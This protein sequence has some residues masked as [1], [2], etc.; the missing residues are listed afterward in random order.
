MPA[1][2]K[3]DAMLNTNQT[4]HTA[5]VGEMLRTWRQRRRLSQLALACDAD[6]SARHLSFLETGRSRPSRQMLTHLAELLDIP[7][8]DRNSLLLAAGFAP[9]HTETPLDNPK[10]AD[11]RRAVEFLLAG[12][13][14]S[15]ALAVD[16]HWTLVAANRAIGLFLEGIAPELLE[17]P[18]NVLRLSLHPQ[19]LAP[20]IVDLR[21]WRGHALERLQKQIDASGDAELMALH[22]ELEAYPC[23]PAS[24]GRK[25]DDHGYGA[26]IVPL[27][28]RSDEG[29]LSFLTTT[30]VFGTAVD[31]TFSELAIESFFPADDFTAEA[32]RKRMPVEG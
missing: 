31:L 23:G 8:R 28:V 29:V 25:P 27:R 26:I 17:P 3:T 20:R 6:V 7:P 22:T 21:Q 19:G 13:E 4:T 9:L 18:I 12:H 30:T 2:G 32:L 10:A 14:P 11:G 16:R 5:Q 1:P 24:D 15:P